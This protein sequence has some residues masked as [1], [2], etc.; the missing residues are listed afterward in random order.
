MTTNKDSSIVVKARCCCGTVYYLSKL[1]AVLQYMSSSTSV[2]VLYYDLKVG[3][4]TEVFRANMLLLAYISS[5]DDGEISWVTKTEGER[6]K[7]KKM[8]KNLAVD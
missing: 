3:N 7:K 5:N 8:Y 2:W 4:A 6:E 1:I